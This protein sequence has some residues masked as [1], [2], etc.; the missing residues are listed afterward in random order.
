MSS[1]VFLLGFF[2]SNVVFLETWVVLCADLAAVLKVSCFFMVLI[3][4]HGK[5]GVK[6]G[7]ML[8]GVTEKGKD[9]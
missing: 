1:P 8:T 5:G 9:G 3:G 7:M 6:R 4:D 2:F